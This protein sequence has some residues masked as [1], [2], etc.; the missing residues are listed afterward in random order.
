MW[1]TYLATQRTL[2]L[3]VLLRLQPLHHALE[4][5]GM[6]AD[7]EHRRTVVA[8]ELDSRAAGLEGGPADAADV[9]VDVPVPRGYS[10]DALHLDSHRGS[11]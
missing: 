4:V 10:H 6:S 7:A 11:M 2:L 9:L 8:G 3:D 5:K 1:V